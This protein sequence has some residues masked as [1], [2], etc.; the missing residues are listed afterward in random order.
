MVPVLRFAIRLR[1]AICDLRFGRLPVLRFAIC[2]LEYA[3]R[4]DAGPAICN[5]L[6]QESSADY[7]DFA[8]LLGASELELSRERTVTVQNKIPSLRNVALTAPYFHNGDVLTL[9]DAVELY[10]RGG[11]VAPILTLDGI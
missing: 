10:S 11:N 6:C 9:R 5:L 3:I 7:A 4:I 8:D 2:N 1:F